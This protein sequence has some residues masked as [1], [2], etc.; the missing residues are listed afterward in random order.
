[1][2]VDPVYL[3][4]GLL[5]WGL[6]GYLVQWAMGALGVPHP[7]DK[8]VLVL[9]VVFFVLWLVSALGLGLPVLRFGSP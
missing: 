6:V 7:V 1:V 8:I 4:V 3:L 9:L 2:I 5:V